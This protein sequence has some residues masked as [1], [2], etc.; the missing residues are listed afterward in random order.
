MTNIL[1]CGP[2]NISAGVSIHMK[3]ISEHLSNMGFNI[4]YYDFSKDS[5]N[6]SVINDFLK[7]YRRTIG[8]FIKAIR[9]NKNYEIL[10][11]QAS[12][13]LP[14]FISAFTGAIISNI[15]NKR[16]IITFHYRPSIQFVKRYHF[17]FSF[18]LNN[19]DTFFVVTNKQ[20]LIIDSTFPW[21]SN[22][23]YV[24]P[25][26]FDESK[27][28]IIDKESCRKALDL[29]KEV[30][31]LLNI[32]NLTEV[33]G[34]SYLIEAVN[35]LIYE[36]KKDIICIIIGSGPLKENLKEK[37]NKLGLKN[38]VFLAGSIN[39][40]DIPIWINAC[41]LFVLSSTIEGNPTVMFE[42]IGCGKPFI[43]TDVGGVSEII[44]SKEYGLLCEPRNSDKLAQNILEALEKK[45]DVFSIN[46][47]SK[48]FRWSSI[49]KKIA[50]I[51]QKN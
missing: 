36:Y 15:L 47:Y 32:G 49:A 10:H 25:N 9:S 13:G 34:H 5:I 6:N 18:V 12:G 43:G 29:Q 19:S 42:S 41:D 16:L 48:Q 24:I 45:W 4:I 33:K 31:I 44:N 40:D 27:F 14:S 2:M 23:T 7:T 26:G 11:I 38:R 8:L 3:Y 50:Y 1:M 39:H 37:I 22:K 30:K 35:K 21:A 17:L 28:K 20:K 46:E 51:Y